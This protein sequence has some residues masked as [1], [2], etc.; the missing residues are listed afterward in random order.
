MSRIKS[1]NVHLG[2]NYVLPLEQTNLSRQEIKMQKMIDDAEVQ[3]N[4]IIESAKTQSQEILNKAKAEAEKIIS[5]ARVQAIQ[6]SEVTKKQGFDEGFKEGL[7]E[8]NDKFKN[9]AALS[10]K[11][12]DTLASSTFEVKKNILKSAEKDIIELV[13]AISLKVCNKV[14]D[15][16]ML[17]EITLKAIDQLK[18]KETITIIVSPELSERI[19]KYSDK[20]KAEIPQLQS[21]KIIEDSSLSCDGV[22]VESPM[23]RVDSRVS[24]QISEITDKLM[25]GVA[26][27]DDELQ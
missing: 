7:A 6:E 14:F 23:T 26:E 20:F 5:D 8:G 19:A 2:N 25:N 17:Y 9:E 4:Q 1:D 12:L 13:T 21:V 18:D 27:N 15:E 16:K 3:K 24:S 10:L 22:I 11:A